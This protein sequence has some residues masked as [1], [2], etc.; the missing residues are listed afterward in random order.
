M[1]KC[2]DV[3]TAPEC[4]GDSD[5]IP[6]RTPAKSRLNRFR[7]AH[8]PGGSIFEAVARAGEGPVC[9]CCIRYTKRI[10]IAWLPLCSD[11]DR[12][13]RNHLFGAAVPRFQLM[14]YPA[15]SC[16][17]LS[18]VSDSCCDATGINGRPKRIRRRAPKQHSLSANYMP[19][20]CSL[21]KHRRRSSYSMEITISTNTV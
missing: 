3:S 17:L 10:A 7:V 15:S 19:Q 5:G 14:L 8:R 12:S 1:K 21:T 9:N 18:N 16:S 4:V 2:G 6:L 11:S 20:Y 13:C